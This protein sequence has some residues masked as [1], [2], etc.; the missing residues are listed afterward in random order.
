[1]ILTVL[2]DPAPIL[3]QHALFPLFLLT[4]CPILHRTHHQVVIGVYGARWSLWQHD[5][6]LIVLSHGRGTS[7]VQSLLVVADQRRHAPTTDSC[8][9]CDCVLC[10]GGL[11]LSLGSTLILESRVLVTIIVVTLL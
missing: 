8:W 9:I 5:Q 2:G 4:R 3:N 10:Q 7:C 1:M 6:I 11:L